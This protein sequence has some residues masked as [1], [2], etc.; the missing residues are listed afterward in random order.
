MTEH[1]VID[2]L[3]QLQDY[4]HLRSNIFDSQMS[5]QWFVRKHRA[6]LTREGALLKLTGRWYVVPQRF[7]DVVLRVGHAIAAQDV[8]SSEA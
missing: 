3:R 7:D 6:V 4:Q 1:N 2:T 8:V 5:L